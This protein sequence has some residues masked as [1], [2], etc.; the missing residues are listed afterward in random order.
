MSRFKPPADHRR[1][2]AD[3]FPTYRLGVGMPYSSW[4]RRIDATGRSRVRQHGPMRSV[5]PYGWSRR[6][7]D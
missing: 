3:L 6:R 4:R 2:E 5:H 7:S 1:G